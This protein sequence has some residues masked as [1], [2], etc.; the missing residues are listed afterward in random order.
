MKKKSVLY[1]RPLSQE[2]SEEIDFH[3]AGRTRELMEEG[4]SEDEARTAALEEFGD[5]ERFR[6]ECVEIDRPEYA[7]HA[8]VS[9]GR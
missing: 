1:R 8:L 4:L 3:L 9:S 7:N 6:S 5:V 2:V